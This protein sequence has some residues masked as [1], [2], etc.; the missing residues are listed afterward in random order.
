MVSSRGRIFIILAMRHRVPSS[1][2]GGSWGLGILAFDFVGGEF[3][4]IGPGW[5]GVRWDDTNF[6]YVFVL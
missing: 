2:F 6:A 4:R 1:F 3:G 5:D